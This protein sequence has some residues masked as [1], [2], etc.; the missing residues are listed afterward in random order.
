MIDGIDYGPLAQLIGKWAGS[1]GLDRAPDAN[2]EPDETSYTDEIVFTIAGAAENAEEQALVALKYH[3]V[4]RKTNNGHI[5]HDQIGHWIFEPSNGIIMHSLTIPR[6]V[7]V[8][9]GGTVEI[10]QEETIFA[11]NATAGSETFGIVQSPFMLEKAKTTEF[12]MILRV[13][14]NELSYKEV[15]SLQ[16][17]GKEFEHVDESTLQRIRYDLE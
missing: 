6:A 10:F 9:A 8:L 16:I 13:K 2:A 4:V 15:T 17:Y 11:V 7:C 3:H 1:R 12:N 5:F 14:E